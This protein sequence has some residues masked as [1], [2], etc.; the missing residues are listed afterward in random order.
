MDQN[1]I[2]RPLT[3]EESHQLLQLDKEMQAAMNKVAQL[4]FSML[5]RKL[6]EERG[7]TQEYCEEV[8]GLYRKFLALNVRYPGKKIC[9]SG[10]VDDFWHAHI[11]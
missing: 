10:P 1:A 2:C 4:E 11:L 6:V 5:G 3:Y 8:E 9:P 7:W